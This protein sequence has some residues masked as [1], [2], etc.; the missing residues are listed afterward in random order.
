MEWGLLDRL[1]AT[2]CPPIEEV[3][4]RAGPQSIGSLFLGFGQTGPAY[5]PRRTVLDTLLVNAAKEAGALCY[6]RFKVDNLIWLNDR[7]IG[8]R[9]TGRSPTICRSLSV[10]WSPAVGTGDHLRRRRTR[11]RAS[12]GRGALGAE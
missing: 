11:D 10:D 9:G 7:V 1:V 8:I 12:G 4:V 5:C 6:D 3:Q 2:G